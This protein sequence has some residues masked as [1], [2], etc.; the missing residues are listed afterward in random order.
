M[1]KA[2]NL[3]RQLRKQILASSEYQAYRQSYESLKKHSDLFSLEKELKVMQ[4]ALVHLRSQKDQD[5]QYLMQSYQE[6][7]SF[8]ENHPL[9]VNYLSDQ[10]D[11]QSLCYYLKEAIEGQLDEK[12]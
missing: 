2:D 6:K 9:V 3:A 10:E 4:K 12:C 8:F 1:N 11:L 5:S 7:R